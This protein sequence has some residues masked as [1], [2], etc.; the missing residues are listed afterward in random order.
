[1]DKENT[2]ENNLRI[3]HDYQGGGN[4]LIPEKDINRK[5]HCKTK[6]T[7]VIDQVYTNSTV[8]FQNS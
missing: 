3:N 7:H 2:N 6:G 5:L 4:V 1:M 8:H